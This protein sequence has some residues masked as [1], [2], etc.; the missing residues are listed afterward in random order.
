MN[1]PGYTAEASLTPAS[2]SYRTFATGTS[3]AS[4]VVVPQSFLLCLVACRC[5]GRGNPN[6]CYVCD[7]CIDIVTTGLTATGGTLM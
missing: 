2:T 1:M 5:C 7:I 6:C 3:D 4:G